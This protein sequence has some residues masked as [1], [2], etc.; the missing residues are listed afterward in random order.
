MTSPFSAFL[1]V[2]VIEGGKRKMIK[3][4]AAFGVRVMPGAGEVG[5]D[6]PDVSDVLQLHTIYSILSVMDVHHG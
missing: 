1:Q 2:N 3:R 4:R 5:F 6:S